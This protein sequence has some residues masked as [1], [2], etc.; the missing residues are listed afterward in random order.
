M[1]AEH[2][3]A[4]DLAEQL[5]TQ[6]QHQADA[7]LQVAGHVARG[8]S[9]AFLGAFPSAR[10][11]LAQAVTLS[12]PQQQQATIALFGMDLGVFGRA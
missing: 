2:Q 4:R 11:H 7:A 10:E 1:R 5:F 9:H 6:T 8:L 3:T 12:T